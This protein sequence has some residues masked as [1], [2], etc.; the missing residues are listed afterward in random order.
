MT[1]GRNA[2]GWVSVYSTHTILAEQ[3]R[4]EDDDERHIWCELNI[5]KDAS[6]LDAWSREGTVVNGKD[7][8]RFKFARYTDAYN[9]LNRWD[10]RAPS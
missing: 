6:G 9:F 2:Q 1:A 3:G 8:A 4:F 10:T 5:D 7:M